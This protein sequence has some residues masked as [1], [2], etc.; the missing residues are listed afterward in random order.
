M[1]MWDQQEQEHEQWLIYLSN[2]YNKFYEY[3]G[4]L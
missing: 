1:Q 2:L 4:T 3:V